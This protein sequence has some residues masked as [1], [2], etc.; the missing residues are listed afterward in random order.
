MALA[1]ADTTARPFTPSSSASPSRQ[2]QTGFLQVSS[3]AASD[4][5]PKAPGGEGLLTAPPR[6]PSEHFDP[7]WSFSDSWMSKPLIPNRP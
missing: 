6:F 5:G 4:E 3:L 1:L 2:Q 7:Y